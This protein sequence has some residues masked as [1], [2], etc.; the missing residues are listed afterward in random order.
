MTLPEMTASGAGWSPSSHVN[1]LLADPG[2]EPPVAVSRLLSTCYLVLADQLPFS[3]V[4]ATEK[5]SRAV[6]E[7]FPIAMGLLSICRNAHEHTDQT[8]TVCSAPSMSH[9][10]VARKF[11]SWHLCPPDVLHIAASGRTLL[12]DRAVVLSARCACCAACKSIIMQ[13]WGPWVLIRPVSLHVPWDHDV[14]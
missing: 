3:H 9:H 1:V 8:M 14:S 13:S 7:R 6:R 11:E 5:L 2:A 10:A 12:L 4:A